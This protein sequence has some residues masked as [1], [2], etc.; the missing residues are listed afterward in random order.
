MNT[1]PPS[2]TEPTELPLLERWGARILRERSA[3][4]DALAAG[5]VHVLDEQEQATLARIERRAILRAAMAGVL[6]ATASALTESL[7]GHHLDIEHTPTLADL[8]T[9]WGIYGLVTAVASVLEIAYLYWDS[10][11]AVRDM[12]SGAGLRLG[13]PKHEST[14]VARA[15]ARAALE[16]PESHEPVLGVDPRRE[17]SRAVLVVA[18]LVYKLKIGLTSFVFKALVRRALGRF[19]TRQLLAFAAVPV[20][21]AWNAVVT[22]TVLREAR[23]RAMGP[24]AIEALLP[25]LLPDPRSLSP[26]ARVAVVRAAGAAIVRTRHAH[27]NLVRWLRRVMETAGPLGE[28]VVLDDTRLFLAHLGGLARDEQVVVLRV[29]AAATILDGRLVGGEVTLLRAALTAAGRSQDLTVVERA[30][31]SFRLGRE[32]DLTEFASDRLPSS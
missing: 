17:A 10:L 22:F 6:S 3:P 26:D 12:A 24:S 27:P 29:L 9:F 14:D 30:A 5:P 8:A 11:T 15:L 32:I 18:T 25:R 31:R 2:P 28:P 16:L 1:E 13:D 23:I 20:N 4:S 7:A 21:A 19:A